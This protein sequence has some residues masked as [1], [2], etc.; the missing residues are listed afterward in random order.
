MLQKIDALTGQALFRLW[1]LDDWPLID[2]DYL[3]YDGCVLVALVRQSGF[4][5]AHIAA[6]PGKRYISRRASHEVISMLGNT[7]IR[8]IIKRGN[9]SVNLAKKLGFT[10]HGLQTLNLINGGPTVCHVLWRK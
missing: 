1:G 3:L 9:R 4:I 6:A 5:D 2:G 7:P 10:D 8:L